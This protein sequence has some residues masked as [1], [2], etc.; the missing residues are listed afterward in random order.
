MSYWLPKPELDENAKVGLSFIGIGYGVVLVAVFPMKQLTSIGV[1]GRFHLA[2]AAVMLVVSYMGYYT[3]RQ[4][5]AAWRV[6]FFNIPLFQ[7][8]IS[9]GILFLYWELGVTLPKSGPPTP[10]SETVIVLIVFAAYLAWDCLE[11]TVQESQ[12][13]I[14]ALYTAN[15]TGML[16][17]LIWDYTCG[18]CAKNSI[19]AER[20]WRRRRSIQRFA[21]DVRASRTITFVFLLLSAAG[22]LI[23]WRCHLRGST[24]VA[25]LDSI[26]IFGLFAYRYC[27]RVWSKFWYQHV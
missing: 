16:P 9:F 6:K 10:V 12:R 26:Y 24:S 5:Y 11:V 17:P 2:L 8:I 4:L 14:T 25:V 13:Y 3:N 7:Y 18:G 15:S 21:K 27:Q 20:R 1:A 23:A 22:W 19:S